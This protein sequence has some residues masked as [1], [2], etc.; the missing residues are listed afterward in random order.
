LSASRLAPARTSL[1]CED[2]AVSFAATDSGFS[3]RDA[4][5]P[6]R[7]MRSASG[8]VS[9]PSNAS[10]EAILGYFLIRARDEH[11]AMELARGSPHLRY[12]GGIEVWR[13]VGRP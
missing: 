7:R 10:G 6:S 2:A 3:V 5:I 9:G 1:L 8:A 11:E 13:L 12:G 4:R